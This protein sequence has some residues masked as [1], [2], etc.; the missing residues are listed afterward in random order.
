VTL[1]LCT[2]ARVYVKPQQALSRQSSVASGS[3]WPD[4]VQRP[5][6]VAVPGPRPV[7]HGA[8]QAGRGATA[9]LPP[10]LQPREPT[11]PGKAAASQQLAALAFKPGRVRPGTVPNPGPRMS[12]QSAVRQH[13]PWVGT[14]G[15]PKK[16][17][18]RASILRGELA[19]PCTSSNGTAAGTTPTILPAACNQTKM[20]MQAPCDETG[21]TTEGRGSVY[22]QHSQ[23]RKVCGVRSCKTVACRS[24]S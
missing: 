9:M 2:R 21:S 18:P 3:P 8:A 13:Q 23:S 5:S 19:A 10:A 7:Q 4:S 11:S 12:Q 6:T 1:L 24:R 17:A 20:G 15:G 16:P 22:L 14:A